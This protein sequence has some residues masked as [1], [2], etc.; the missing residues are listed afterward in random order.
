[1]ED[2]P[3]VR[4]VAERTLRQAGYAVVSA[5]DGR[6]AIELARR[7]ED[8]IHLLVADVSLPHI[9]GRQLAAE[10]REVH[11]AV[12]TLFMSEFADD[13]FRERLE[14]E[15]AHLLWKP[16]TRDALARAVRRVL[17]DPARLA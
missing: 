11:P 17:D 8:P 3:L 12:R 6:R 5:S 4:E 14:S 15:G 7:H 10:V 13:D 2:E 9:S 1:V 16:F